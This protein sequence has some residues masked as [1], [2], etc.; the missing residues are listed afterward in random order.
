MGSYGPQENGNCC[1]TD[2]AGVAS[3]CISP[4][5]R[6]SADGPLQDSS[7][8][9]YF[10][11]EL[12]SKGQQITFPVHPGYTE[13]RSLIRD[14]R[15]EILDDLTNEALGFISSAFDE[16]REERDPS[17]RNLVE[18]RLSDD[19]LKWKE[20]QHGV[21]CT[22]PC[23]GQGLQRVSDEVIRLFGAEKWPEPLVT[24]DAIFGCGMANML[25]G[26]YDARTLY[27]NYVTDMVFYYE[28]SYHKVFPGFE[29]LIREENTD[30]HAVRTPAGA[31][32]R[33]AV[34]IGARYIKGKIDLE[35]KYKSKLSTKMAKL[36]RRSAQVVF[37]S[38]SSL[39][40]MSAETIVRGFDPAAVMSD[41]IFS[42]PGTDVVD[43]GSDLYNSEVMNAFLNTADITDTGIV[44]EDA[45]RRVYDAYAHTG[46]RMFTER[47]MEP[48]ARMCATLYTWHILNDRH[49]F[50]RRALLGYPKAR[51]TP[52]E[53]CEG[54]FDEVFDENLRTT[55]FSRPL[56]NAC[57]GG[58]PC[59]AV[60]RLLAG[61]EYGGLLA[62]L[63]WCLST[64]PVKY[65]SGGVADQAREEG[66]VKALKMTMAKAFSEG[67][68]L[69]TTWLLAHANHHAWQVNYLFEAAMFGSLLDDGGLRGKLDRK[70]HL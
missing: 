5:R 21:G 19:L 30:L 47:W 22:L 25:I 44:T 57:N 3:H 43:V 49:R 59:D 37:F 56:K 68:I 45:L 15:L 70:E 60:E 2:T 51:K 9:P 31:E 62:M 24:S 50:C 55:G 26:A 20:E 14:G 40:G 46:G 32:R 23:K 58:D 7:I 38:E 66:I 69:E 13:A 18:L 54:D 28:H 67:L 63:W 52:G 4:A 36:D 39:M 53:Q 35:V 65:A 61:H 29:N 11:G 41:M 17:S 6:P 34:G 64:G 48:V 33:A 1:A 10:W 27:S 12:H 42:S 8:P 16:L